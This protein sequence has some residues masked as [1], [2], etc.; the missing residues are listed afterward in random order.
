M[1][2]VQCQI[3]WSMILE[4]EERCR[5]STQD[6]DY[7]SCMLCGATAERLGHF[8]SLGEEE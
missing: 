6:D 5:V 1:N 7:L 8:I 3:C 4:G 2:E